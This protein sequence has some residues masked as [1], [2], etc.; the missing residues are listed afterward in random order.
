MCMCVELYMAMYVYVHACVCGS[1]ISILTRGENLRSQ[2]V[3]VAVVIYSVSLLQVRLI[4][5]F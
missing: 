2:A 4:C 5:M 3:L 1:V